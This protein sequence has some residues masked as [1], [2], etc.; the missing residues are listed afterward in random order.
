M[1]CM[2]DG[3]MS[4]GMMLLGGLLLLLLLGM[5]AGGVLLAAWLLRHTEHSLTATRA[6]DSPLDLLK[7]RLAQGEITPDEY[8]SLKH[9][10]QE[11]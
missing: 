7:Q 5:A 3:M 9:Q 2:M 1:T 6:I 4:G 11:S 8:S 10:L